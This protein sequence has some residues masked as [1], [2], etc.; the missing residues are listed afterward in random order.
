MFQ[1]GLKKGNITRTLCQKRE[2]CRR[3][4]AYSRN[5]ANSVGHV[6]RYAMRNATQG[7]VSAYVIAYVM[8]DARRDSGTGI[9]GT[10]R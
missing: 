5:I 10:F 7:L 6:L 3:G 8:G 1:N 4:A 2:H 9:G